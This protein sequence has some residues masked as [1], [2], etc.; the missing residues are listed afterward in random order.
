MSDTD[1]SPTVALPPRPVADDE[2]PDDIPTPAPEPPQVGLGVWVRAVAVVL[3]CVVVYAPSYAD[4]VVD[5]FAGSRAAYLVVLPV[6]LA[7][8]IATGYRTASHGVGDGESD[9]IV[10]ALIG[11]LGLAAIHLLVARMPTLSAWWRLE[12]LS[13]LVWAVCSVTILFGMRQVL[14]MWPLWLFLTSFATPVPYLAATAAWAG[15]QLTL[16]CRLPQ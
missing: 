6:F 10:A 8:L 2:L 15:H 9:W 3:F 12:S 11:I 16:D 5:A 13:V 4:H 7:I 14:Q 1:V